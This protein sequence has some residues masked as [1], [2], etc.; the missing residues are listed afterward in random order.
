[1]IYQKLKTVTVCTVSEL[2]ANRCEIIVA[3][4]QK[5]VFFY[6]IFHFT[7]L[8]L[9][10]TGFKLSL[11]RWCEVDNILNDGCFV[12]LKCMPSLGRKRLIKLWRKLQRKFASVSVWHDW[13]HTCLL[14]V[15]YGCKTCQLHMLLYLQNWMYSIRIKSMQTSPGCLE[16]CSSFI[17]WMLIFLCTLIPLTAGSTG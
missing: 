17:C 2:E 6:F 8:T 15:H 1:M 7:V 14:Q 3:H 9:D 11:R 10:Q 4:W 16:I 13:H 12:M 5:N